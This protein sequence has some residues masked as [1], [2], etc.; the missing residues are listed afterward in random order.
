MKKP[1]EVRDER[2]REKVTLE[3]EYG[4][5]AGSGERLDVRA[6]ECSL[7]FTAPLRSLNDTCTLC[8]FT[9]FV[10]K[11]LQSPDGLSRLRQKYENTFKETERG[12][13]Q[14][15]YLYLP[16]CYLTQPTNLNTTS[17]FLFFS[18]NHE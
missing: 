5:R 15:L 12:R 4:Q 8:T 10:L 17:L 13:E 11:V 6:Q 2:E 14:I 3:G 9:R 7:R 1:S 16:Q 18:A